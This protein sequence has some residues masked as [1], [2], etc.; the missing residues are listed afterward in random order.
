M[1]KQ[2]SVSYSQKTV[3]TAGAAFVA[4]KVPSFAVAILVC[5]E[6]CWPIA[7]CYEYSNSKAFDLVFVMEACHLV[8]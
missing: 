5:T 7:F 4:V 2:L 6:S 1:L 8:A 3:I